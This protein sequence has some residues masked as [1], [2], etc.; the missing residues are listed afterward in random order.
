VRN[1][2]CLVAIRVG[3]RAKMALTYSLH[4]DTSGPMLPDRFAEPP[5]KRVT[6]SII[7][8]RNVES[9]IEPYLLCTY[10]HQEFAFE[11]PET[12]DRRITPIPGVY[13]HRAPIWIP[14]SS[15]PP[16]SNW[17]STERSQLS[18]FH[19]AIRKIHEGHTAEVSWNVNL[20][21]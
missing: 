6:V 12:T 3:Y 4:P 21:V 20:T 14:S 2:Y 5:T 17:S 9:C 10:H 8:V 19:D 15:R 7:K 1:L 11:S 13:G 16:L 18:N